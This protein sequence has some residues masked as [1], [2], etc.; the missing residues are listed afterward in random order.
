M[1]APRKIRVWTVAMF[2]K[3]AFNDDRPPACRRARRLLKKID[4]KHRG[5]LLIPSGGSNREF[6]FMPAV[7]MRLEPDYFTPVEAIE[8]RLDAVEEEVGELRATQRRTIGQVGYLS[9]E[10][11]KLQRRHAP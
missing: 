3:H 7:L 5:K 2:A 6:T 4:K 8:F 10:M 11:T 1:S 9:R